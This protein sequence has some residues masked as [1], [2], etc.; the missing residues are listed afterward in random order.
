VRSPLLAGVAVAAALAPPAQAARVYTLAGG[1]AGGGSLAGDRAFEIIGDVAVDARGDVAFTETGRDRVR[2]V[3][4]A[5]GLRTTR[6]HSPPLG[7]A[8][9]PDGTPPRCQACRRPSARLPRRRIPA[10][11]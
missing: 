10:C 3:S 4:P 11:C 2:I 7:I 8:L 5:S 9:E 6:L 1:G